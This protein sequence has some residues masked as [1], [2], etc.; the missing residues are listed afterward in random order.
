M[1]KTF[2]ININGQLFNIDEDAF[3]KLND[4]L[5]TLKKHFK[6]TEGGEDIVNDI[7]A[8]IAEILKSRLNDIQQIVVLSDV[9]FCI[10]TLG[11]P[12]E[13]DE[14][15]DNET[16][17]N[18]KRSYSKKR[19]FRD[20]DNQIIGGVA[21]GL[22]AY[23][24]MD[25]VIIRLIFILTILIGGVGIVVY[26]TLWIL[27]PLATTTAEKIEMSGENV[28]IQSIEK[29]VREELE[30]LKI[31]I[32]DF[33]NEAGDVIKK[34]QKE[35]IPAIEKKF[36]KEMETFKDKMHNFTNE[37]GDVLKKKKKD[38]VNGFNQM[39]HA[40]YNITRVFFR[41]LAIIIGFVFL[42]VG[43]ALSLVFAAT[44][45]GII[46]NFQ[47]D[48]LSFITISLPEFLTQYIITTPYQM[49]MNLALFLVIAIPIIAL[50]FNGI[51]L[52]FNLGRQ[53]ELGIGTTIL[54]T[55]A[56]F[57]VITLSLKTVEQFKIESKQIR[58][59]SLNTL[60]S[61]T[62]NIAIFNPEY[63][64]EIVRHSS[65]SVYFEDKGTMISSHNIFYGSPEIT[66]KKAEN[67][68][69]EISVRTSVRGKNNLEADARLSNTKYHFELDKNTLLLDPFFTL[70]RN[71]KW[72]DQQVR[73]EI[74]IPEGKT[75]YIDKEMRNYFQWEYWSH[76]KRRMAGNYWIMTS[77]GLKNTSKN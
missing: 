6:D 15:S 75:I 51:R 64:K 50:I 11:Q 32:Q 39:G 25:P 73:F 69:F 26:L 10:E 45:L 29:K 47:F 12:F 44:Y 53:K 57:V 56:L 52:I 68:D 13:M 38:S 19:I 23:F 71:E 62:L 22:A 77:E 30:R 28:D 17:A 42:I 34:T 37:A 43:I 8:R 48:E 76:S 61:D 1:K 58:V 24:N 2:S 4:Y 66:F 49:T 5:K 27:T 14:E 31:K 3:E 59:E 74:L 41:A 33:S 35:S 7:E 70:T 21:S 67:T 18:G 54:W 55:I 63:N 72:R 40:V 46:P 16:Y 36:N 9:D 20:P 65:G 60:S